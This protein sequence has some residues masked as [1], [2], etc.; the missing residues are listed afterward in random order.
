MTNAEIMKIMFSQSSIHG[1]TLKKSPPPR[2]TLFETVN[3]FSVRNHKAAQ[4]SFA[5]HFGRR[6]GGLNVSFALRIH[7][8]DHEN[9]GCISKSEL[10]VYSGNFFG[11]YDPWCK[12][13]ELSLRSKVDDMV[14]F[15][16]KFAAQLE[17]DLV[18]HVL[19]PN[20]FIFGKPL[21]FW[22]PVDLSNPQ[23]LGRP[24]T[25]LT[26]PPIILKAPGST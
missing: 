14:L 25:K 6:W 3:R 13:D 7:D 15:V 16:G 19:T 20:D 22:L 12:N 8:V 5:G 2:S 4:W 1:Y 18:D 11:D 23:A 9:N 17:S 21:R 24:A 10:S 26:I